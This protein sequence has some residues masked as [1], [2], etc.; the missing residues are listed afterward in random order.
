LTAHPVCKHAIAGLLI[1]PLWLPAPALANDS[2]AELGAGGIVL[3]LNSD[4]EMTS[5]DLYISAREVRVRYVFTNRVAQDIR[6]LVAF[7]MPDVKGSEEPQS[8]PT[9]D[10]ANILGFTTTV[11]GAPVLARVEQKAFANSLEQTQRLRQLGVPLA[12]HLEGTQKALTALPRDQWPVLEKLGLV[13]IMKFDAGRGWQE[14]L[15][16][17]WTLRTTWYWD[18]LFAANAQTHVEHR[19]RP[20]VGASAGTQVGDRQAMR[21]DWY[22]DYARKYCIDS[23]FVAAI[24]RARKTRGGDGIPF[25]EE[26]ISYILTTG[27]NWAGPIRDFRLVVD[28]GAPQNL[29]SFCAKGVKRISSTQFEVRYSDFTPRTDLHVLILKPIK[30]E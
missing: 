18:Q 8:I 29:V 13:E 6:T 14:E 23:S 3:R 4:V 25:T 16:P 17:R 1:C 12:P 10:P 19:Y 5:E 30:I 24:D 2:S 20:S 28:K 22:R 7:P 15:A 27:A 21:E 11:N 26:R 9:E